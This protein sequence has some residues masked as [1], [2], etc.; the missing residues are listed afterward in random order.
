MV[1]DALDHLE[2]LQVTIKPLVKVD[3]AFT[4]DEGE[5]DRTRKWRLDAHRRYFARQAT[6]DGFELNDGIPT[7]FER[8]D[9]VGRSIRRVN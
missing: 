6:R 7:V 3:E 2:N 9:V 8:F 4:W 1:S 5:E